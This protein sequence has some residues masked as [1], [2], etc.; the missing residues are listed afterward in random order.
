[1]LSA[2]LNKTFLSLNPFIH[3][4]IHYC[5]HS[6]IHLFIH[7]LHHPSSPFIHP[8]IH[9]SHPSFIHPSIH[10]SS[11]YPSIHS[12]I[13]CHH[14]FSDEPDCLTCE[15]AKTVL[16]ELP[17]PDMF[18]G[19]KITTP[20]PHQSLWICYWRVHTTKLNPMDNHSTIWGYYSYM[21]HFSLH[22]HHGYEY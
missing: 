7:S 12:F 1:M 16:N 11:I 18:P 4:S 21:E 3:P 2:L 8:F 9:P 20:Y 13:H 17:E 14:S 6:F 19:G 10:H 5:I 22:T 15:D